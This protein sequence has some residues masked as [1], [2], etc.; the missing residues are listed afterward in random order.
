MEKI[1][2]PAK[3]PNIIA[4]ATVRLR[5]V[6][7][8]ERVIG[9]AHRHEI[10]SA[11]AFQGP[12]DGHNL[13]FLAI[14]DEVW[15]I[16]EFLP[17]LQK[18]FPG[19]RISVVEEE[20]LHISPADFL[21]CG[22]LCRRPL[23]IQA[24]H[25]WWVFAGGALGGAARIGLESG[26]RYI[27][28]GYEAFPWGT[29]AVNISGSFVIAILGTLAVERFIAE[30]ERLFWIL[31]FLGSFTT[32]SSFVLETAQTWKESALLGVLYGGG[33]IL[34]GLAAVFLGIWLTRRALQW[35]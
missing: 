27:T 10:A 29:I 3:R 4:Q 25:L 13:I 34:L 33:T 17:Q 30:R 32:F 31:G 24:E 22:R 19:V 12:E 11:M 16:E 2:Q 14:I 6:A 28:Q 20:V 5:S 8:C 35:A 7:E 26:A 15:R 1:Q 23:R 21:H 9:L 18:G